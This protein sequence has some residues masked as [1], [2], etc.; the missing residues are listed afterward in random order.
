MCRLNFSV[1][2]IPTFVSEITV[3]LKFKAQMMIDREVTCNSTVN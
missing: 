2:T 1:I 3:G